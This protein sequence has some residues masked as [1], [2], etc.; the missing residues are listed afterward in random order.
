MTNDD[1]GGVDVKGAFSFFNVSK[2]KVEGV[3]EAFEGFS[4]GDRK[5][6][7]ELTKTSNRLTEKVEVEIDVVVEEEIHLEIE[8]EVLGREIDLVLGVEESEE[9]NYKAHCKVGFII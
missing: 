9:N 4:V 3:F 5:V 8:E 1:F 6:S 7:L 2:S